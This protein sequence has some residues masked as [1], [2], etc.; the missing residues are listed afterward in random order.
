MK[1]LRVIFI[2][3]IL[4]STSFVS[5]GEDKIVETTLRLG[6]HDQGLGYEYSKFVN[7]VL[8]LISERKYDEAEVLL[9][10]AIAGFKQT[11]KNDGK[12][13]LYRSFKT[14]KEFL[15]YQKKVKKEVVWMDESY[16]RAYHLK[17]YICVNKN[18]LKRAKK[19]FF[20][21][22]D[23]APFEAGV[24]A[25]LGFIANHEKNKPDALKYYKKALQLA[26]QFESQMATKPVA[27]RGLGFVLIEMGKLDEAEKMYKKA[28]KEDPSSKLALSELRY[29]DVLRKKAK[30]NK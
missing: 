29:I 13:A 4:F 10:K 26:E 2:S 11:I 22:H 27:L 19:L 1:I 7:P 12:S 6:S 30:K 23:I 8:K 3:L 25:E 21:E 9:N 18:D 15:A 5:L 17:A 28:L 14:K 24:F 20:L 16:A